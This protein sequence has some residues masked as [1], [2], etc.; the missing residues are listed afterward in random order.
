MIPDLLPHVQKNWASLGLERKPKKLGC[1][2]IPSGR[3]RHARL[4]QAVA[5]IYDGSAAEPV[6]IAKMRRGDSFVKESRAL[7][8]LRAEVSPRLARH[9]PRPLGTARIGDFFAYFESPLGGRP[10]AE[11]NAGFKPGETGYD[12]FNSGVFRRLGSTLRLLYSTPK[13]FETVS[14]GMFAERVNP[15][16]SGVASVL[17]LKGKAAAALQA[18]FEGIFDAHESLE[19][20]NSLSHPDL[21]PYNALVPERGSLMNLIDWEVPVRTPL[22]M[23]DL[24]TFALR[25]FVDSFSRRLVRGEFATEFGKAFVS[26]SGPFGSAFAE[27]IRLTGYPKEFAKPL[28]ALS[29]AKEVCV[30][31]ENDCFPGVR[32]IEAKMLEEYLRAEFGVEA[33]LTRFSGHGLYYTNN[34]YARREMRFLARMWKRT[35]SNAG[36]ALALKMRV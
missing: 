35:A 19:L 6:L 2:L 32:S 15:I 28:L 20:P 8:E 21:S 27:G 34:T 3:K 36:K 17:S 33:D 22:P 4:C 14:A 31:G 5:I 30:Q 16:I 1:R 7:K 12:S 26:L 11:M 25:H 23:C 18:G 10:V 13:G 29:F 9:I 24:N